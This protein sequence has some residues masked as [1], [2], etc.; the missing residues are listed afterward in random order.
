[1]SRKQNIRTVPDETKDT[2]L[3]F[4]TLEDENGN[5]HFEI[6]GD[7]EKA[8]L[9]KYQL[10]DGSWGGHCFERGESLERLIQA[11]QMAQEFTGTTS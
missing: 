5:Y 9:I 4:D 10:K 3:L 8:Y 2:W 7:G 11:L 1:M 6:R